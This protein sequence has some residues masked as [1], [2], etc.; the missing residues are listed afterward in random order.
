M[1]LVVHGE[2]LLKHHVISDLDLK[3]RPQEAGV[4]R[5]AVFAVGAGGW[6]KEIDSKRNRN[7]D[8]TNNPH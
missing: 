2:V 4:H 5:S 1:N 6:I 8:T 7:D 3:F